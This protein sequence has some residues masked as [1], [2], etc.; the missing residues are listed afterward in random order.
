MSWF[1]SQGHQAAL[2]Y[3]ASLANVMLAHAGPTTQ[4]W[5]KADPNLQFV[6]QVEMKP[7]ESC[8]CSASV[9][10]KA[11]IPASIPATIKIREM[12]DQTT[13]QH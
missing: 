1:P 2:R 5:W 4:E 9:C 12:M 10:G 3:N 11:A 6:L 7:S 13:P 8:L